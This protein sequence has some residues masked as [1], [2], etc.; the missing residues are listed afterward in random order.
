MSEARMTALRLENLTRRFQSG[1]ETLEIL[2]GA[3]FSLFSGEIVALVAPSGTGKS[4][5]LHLAGLLEAP[6]EGTVYIDEKPVSGLSDAVR[7][8]VR[9]DQIGFVYQFHHLLG[10]FTA[11][12]NVMLPQLVAGVSA[13]VAKARAED[14][15]GRF[16]LSHRLN[17]LPGRLSGG[18]QQRTAIARALANRPKLLLADEPTGNLDIGTSD[19]VFDELLRVVREEGVAAL[20][21]THNKELAARMDRT[22]TLR[23]GKL[24]A[25]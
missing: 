9:R 25:F 16:G 21:A 10:E 23:D 14:L 18:E 8:A 5:L 19:H 12:E 22:V 15:L 24:V 1:E 11:C 13:K 17:S 2:S 6:T 7:T 3:E 4:T 20:I